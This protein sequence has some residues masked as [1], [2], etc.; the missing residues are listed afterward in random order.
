MV[1]GE[2]QPMGTVLPPGQFATWRDS[3]RDWILANSLLISVIDSPRSGLHSL[4]ID[5]LVLTIDWE[6]VGGAGVGGIIMEF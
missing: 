4:N 5:D 2:I 6:P 1:R 3:A